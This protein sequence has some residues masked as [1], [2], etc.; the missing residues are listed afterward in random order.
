MGSCHSSSAPTILWPPVRIPSTPTTLF[1]ICIA[2][3]GTVFDI[4][5]RKGRK[6]KKD[7]EIGPFLKTQLTTRGKKIIGR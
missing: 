1:S 6:I 3:I 5:M 2:E 4:G 7:A